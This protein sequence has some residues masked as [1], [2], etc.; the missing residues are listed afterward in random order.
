VTW[1]GITYK[2]L[3]FPIRRKVYA[4]TSVENRALVHPYGKSVLFSQ[5]EK[6]EDLLLNPIDLFVHIQEKIIATNNINSA[7]MWNWERT[8]MRK[9]THD[10]SASVFA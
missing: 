3:K 5:M 6:S 1:K 4:I 2:K 7:G 8:L 10:F 9:P